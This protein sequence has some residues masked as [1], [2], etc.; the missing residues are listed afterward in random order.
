MAVASSACR[1]KLHALGGQAQ[2]VEPM[3]RVADLVGIEALGAELAAELL[4]FGARV[5]APV[6]FVD[7]HEHFEHGANIAHAIRAA[8]GSPLDGRS[9]PRLVAGRGRRAAAPPGRRVRVRAAAPAAP[10]RSR[11]VRAHSAS[12]LDGVEARAA[13]SRPVVRAPTSRRAS[14]RVRSMGAATSAASRREAAVLRARRCTDSTSFAP[15][16]ISAW[17]PRDCGEWIEPGMANT[18][19]ALFGGEP[20]GDQRAGLQRGLDHQRAARQARR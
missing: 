6:V 8:G 9:A 19:R 15:W 2:A 4:G 17:Q 18:S 13:R 5:A 20:G 1:V 12:R 10:P 3:Q 16:R 11:P 7:E 14:R